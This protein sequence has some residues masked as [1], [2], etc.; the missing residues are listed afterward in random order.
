MSTAFSTPDDAFSRPN[1][2]LSSSLHEDPSL[3]AVLLGY[4]QGLDCSLSLTGM[5]DAI[6]AQ[7]DAD[8]AQY[9]IQQHSQQPSSMQTHLACDDLDTLWDTYADNPEY[10]EAETRYPLEKLLPQWPAAQ[11]AIGERQALIAALRHYTQRTEAACTFIANVNTLLSAPNATPAT[12]NPFPQWAQLWARTGVAIASIAALWV[13]ML[14]PSALITTGAVASSETR[15]KDNSLLA[16]AS[17]PSVEAYV[18]TYCDD[19]LMAPMDV[20]NLPDASQVVM[21]GCGSVN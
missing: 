10:V 2:E 12:G 21:M 9:P 8:E 4:T 3:Q 7:L 11:Q 5:W 13:L 18:M 17:A 1:S 19:A 20:P 6:D 16:T 15:Q 14:D